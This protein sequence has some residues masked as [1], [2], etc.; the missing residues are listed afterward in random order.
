VHPVL[1][2]SGGTVTW[3]V[4]RATGV[5]TLGFLTASVL[6]GI[7]TS[8]RWSS[9]TWPRF[10]VE[11]VHRNVSLLVLVFLAIHV[12]TVVADSFAPI[13]WIDVVI[14]FVS[15]Y[16]PFWLGLGAVAVDLLIALVVTSLLRHRIGFTTWRF[17]HWLAYACWPVAVLHGLGTGSDTRSGLVLVFTA[18]CVVSVLVA[19][20]LRVGAGLVSRPRGRALGFAAVAV[21]PVLLVIWLVSG[22]LA[23]GWARKAGTPDSVLAAVSGTTAPGTAGAAA[24]S[25]SGGKTAPTQTGVFPAAGFDATAQGT[26][27]E[28]AARS[29]GQVVLSLTGTLSNGAT[30]SVDVE[31]TGTPLSDGGVSMSSGTVALSDGANS[32]RGAVVGLGASQVVADMPGPGGTS[33]RVSVDFTQLDQQRGVMAADVH[34]GRGDRVQPGRNDSGGER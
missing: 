28:G 10:V 14:P 31:L 29:K 9:P 6:L 4:A 24:A 8:F 22:P 3:Y 27:R 13:R 23:D 12:V 11:F 26:L 1:A 15:A 5:V 7:L 33:W 30:G 2:L 16:R 18:A 19:A 32:Y 20:G 25:S 17:V 34:V 21:A